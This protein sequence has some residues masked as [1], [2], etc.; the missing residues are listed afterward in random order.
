M[1]EADLLAMVSKSEEFDQIKVW[2][3]LL[4]LNSLVKINVCNWLQMY[5][6]VLANLLCILFRSEKMSSRNSRS[7]FTQSAGYL[8]KEV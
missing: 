2:I 6:L 7:I 8:S 1:T 5:K 4:N 3:L